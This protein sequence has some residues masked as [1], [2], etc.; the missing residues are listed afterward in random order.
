[1]ASIEVLKHKKVTS[2]VVRYSRHGKR[3]K[4]SL[5]CEYTKRDAERLAAAITSAIYAEKKE[6]PLDRATTLFF[7]NLTPDLR[8]RLINAGLIRGAVSITLQEAK[9]RF[10]KEHASQN[11]SSTV[12]TYDNAFA[13]LETV[14]TPDVKVD[15]ITSD[16]M[17]GLKEKMN[18][19]YAPLTVNG[20]LVRL[21]T[22]FNF[23]KRVGVISETPLASIATSLNHE[24]SR[25]Y[26]SEEAVVKCFPYLEPDQRLILALWRF[27]GLRRSEPMYLT[28]ACVDLVERKLTVFSPKTERTGHASR[29]A[30]ICP[31]LSELLRDY[32][33]TLK[34]DALFERNLTVSALDT[35]FRKAGVRWQRMAQDL[36]VSCENDWL[37]SKLPAHV[38]A[39][40]IGHNVNVQTKHYAIV[41]DEYFKSVTESK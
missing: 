16:V 32:L 18:A 37:K 14:V 8:R 26:V 15:L 29:V 39:R 2:Y 31:L 27:A 6:E 40:W 10:Y 19:V 41:L 30:P 24:G 4:I 35:A 12:R 33:K 11:K 9:E 22:F 23:L 38:V 34:T 7:E 25:A 13:M 21:K 5:S 20:T 28:K 1:M 3:C 17:L 36:R